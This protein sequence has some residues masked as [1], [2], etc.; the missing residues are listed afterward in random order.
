MSQVASTG[1]RPFAVRLATPRS[2][3]DATLPDLERYEEA[4]NVYKRA[5]EVSPN[6]M[7]AWHQKAVALERLAQQAH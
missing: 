2:V 3:L 5:I 6:N 4:L 1:S 7:W